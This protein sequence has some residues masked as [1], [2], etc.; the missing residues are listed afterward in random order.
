MVNTSEYALKEA[1]DCGGQV[2]I[3]AGHDDDGNLIVSHGVCDYCLKNV[4]LPSRDY[5][6]FV[7]SNCVLA[8]R[9]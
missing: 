2:I 7:Q 8:N 9:A 1:C 5:R 4:I 3:V 6:Q